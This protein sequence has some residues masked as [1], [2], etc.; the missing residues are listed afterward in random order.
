MHIIIGVLTAA[1]GLIWALY[2]LQNS[3]VDL[4][5]FNP[6]YWLRRRKWEKQLGTKAMH[7]LENPMEAAALL[8]AAVASCEAEVTRE[9]RGEVTALFEEEFQIP[10]AKA[11]ELF[12]ASMHL[13]REAGNLDAEVRPI[14]APC[15]E[16]LNSEQIESLLRM[17]RRA[18]DFEANAK[19]E[20]ERII[21]CVEKELSPQLKTAN[22]TW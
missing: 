19:P 14:L 20:K 2:R 15:R 3:G 18:A 12:S 7:R 13:L 8:V 9:L 10:N 21:Q 16:K 6:F 4:N 22:S 17:L 5:A 11:L 1:A